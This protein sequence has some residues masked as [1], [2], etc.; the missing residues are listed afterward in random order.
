MSAMAFVS[1]TPL[2]E[3]ESVSKYVAQSVQV[4]KD[5]GLSWQLTPMGTIIEGEKLDE[6]LAVVNK[7]V[8]AQEECERISISV[9]IDYR[10][11]KPLGLN[12]KVDSVMKKL[13]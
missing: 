13:K 9:K 6:V 8:Q 11:N 4:I 3:G 5:S 2:G 12:T 7:A 10:K 1:I